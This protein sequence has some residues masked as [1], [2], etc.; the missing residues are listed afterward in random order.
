MFLQ[1]LLGSAAGT[2]GLHPL[3]K[4]AFPQVLG[5]LTYSRTLIR[6]AS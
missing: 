4:R 6:K 5:L 2:M 3:L 1:F